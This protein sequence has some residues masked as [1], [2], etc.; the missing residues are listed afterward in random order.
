M[1]GRRSIDG[2]KYRTDR[3]SDFDPPPLFVPTNDD[4]DS[5]SREKGEERE[6]DNQRR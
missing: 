6:R 1:D 4:D 3:V 5:K 2:T